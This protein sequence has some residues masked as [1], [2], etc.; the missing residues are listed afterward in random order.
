MKRKYGK[1]VVGGNRNGRT[2][3]I[4]ITSRYIFYVWAFFLHVKFIFLMCITSTYPDMSVDFHVSVYWGTFFIFCLYIIYTSISYRR[5]MNMKNDLKSWAA[6]KEDFSLFF[7]L[8][9]NIF[10]EAQKQKSLTNFLF[11]LF[12]L[13]S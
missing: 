11:L 6:I 12:T 4:I 7:C 3:I 2:Q 5:K 9:L 10:T 13:Y 1:E 8:P